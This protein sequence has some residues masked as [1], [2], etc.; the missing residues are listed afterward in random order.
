MRKRQ[1]L[2][3]Q[4][5][6][7]LGMKNPITLVVVKKM[8]CSDVLRDTFPVHHHWYRQV[9]KDTLPGVSTLVDLYPDSPDFREPL[10]KAED[11]IPKFSWWPSNSLN[12]PDHAHG[13]PVQTLVFS[14]PETRPVRDDC[15]CCEVR[16]LLVCDRRVDLDEGLCV[17]LKSPV[18]DIIISPVFSTIGDWKVLHVLLESTLVLVVLQTTEVFVTP[19]VREPTL[20]ERPLGT[21]VLSNDR[22]DV[23]H[24]EPL[25]QDPLRRSLMLID[26]GLDHLVGQ[27]LRHGHCTDPNDMGV[28]LHG[29]DSVRDGHESLS[30]LIFRVVGLVRLNVVQQNKFGPGVIRVHQTQNAG[31]DAAGGKRELV[32]PIGHLL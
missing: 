23:V 29:E 32:L 20:P 13:H 8:F 21:V 11:S 28:L 16:R 6:E 24:L 14:T 22:W 15:E 1:H 2:V 19:V 18:L 26:H 9:V 12:L 30:A 3:F 25:I 17:L 10:N 4:V 7:S 27:R 31:V 5:R